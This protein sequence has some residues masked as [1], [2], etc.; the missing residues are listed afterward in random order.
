MFNHYRIKK[1][2]DG[3]KYSRTVSLYGVN[4]RIRVVAIKGFVGVRE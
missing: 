2:L 4:F 1:I 3:I